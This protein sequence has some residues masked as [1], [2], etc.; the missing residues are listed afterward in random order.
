M[1]L[2]RLLMIPFVAATA[3]CEIQEVV[4]AQPEDIVVAEVVLAAG[5]AVQTAWLH[6]TRVSDP[7]ADPRVRDADI[8]VQAE[9]GRVL[10]FDEAADTM[11][12]VR[13]RDAGSR[14]LGTCYV[15]IG[16]SSFVQPGGTYQ[17]AIET[18]DGRQ[19]AGTTT[20]PGT[21]AIVQPATGTAT[22]RANTQY[23]VVWTQSA[24]TWVYVI[25]GLFHGLRSA[26]SPLEVPHE[27]LLLTGLSIS[28]T[29]TTV[30]VPAEIGIF[31]RFDSDLTAV[32]VELQ[33]GLPAN[34]DAE[35]TVSAADRNY[36]NWVRAGSFNPSGQVRVPSIHGERGTGVFGS[37]VQRSV[38][39]QARD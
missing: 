21:F 38:V 16:A 14:V 10:R 12:Y 5:E 2:L 15:A 18:A 4:I 7:N 34:V 19:L 31:D 9:D 27:P 11:C 37:V 30:A 29:D 23:D 1:R 26:L 13:R 22:I 3:G 28:G 24:N 36:V 17:L 39:L 32:L 6:H 25:D 35:I 20:V 8:V 33:K